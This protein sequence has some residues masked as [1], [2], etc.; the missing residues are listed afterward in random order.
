MRELPGSMT[1]SS[2]RGEALALLRAAERIFIAYSSADL[3]AA[4][5]LRRRIVRIRHDRPVESVFMASDSL[6]VG[7]SIEPAHIR[8]ALARADLFVVA[9][10]RT[11][12]GSAWVVEEVR[13]ALLQRADGRTRILPVILTAKV[14]LPP[15]I[16]FAI[17]AIHRATLFP[18]IRRVQA[19]IA[20][21]VLALLAAAIGAA[22]IALDRARQRDLAALQGRLQINAFQPGEATDLVRRNWLETQRAE[23]RRLNARVETAAIDKELGRYGT[24]AMRR[25]WLSAD[26][27][28]RFLAVDPGAPV[29]WVGY[30]DRI[31][32]RNAADGALERAFS[33]RSITAI[34]YEPPPVADATPAVKAVAT[35]RSPARLVALRADP[36]VTG[37]LAEVEYPDGFAD[38]QE[39]ESLAR[40]GYDATGGEREVFC[41]TRDSAAMQTVGL[42]L[43]LT[44]ENDATGDLGAYDAPVS[45]AD[46]VEAALSQ[47]TARQRSLVFKDWRRGDTVERIA[48]DPVTGSALF[49][50]VRDMT[51]RDDHT[52][53]FSFKGWRDHWAV[54]LSRSGQIDEAAPITKVFPAGRR[55][56]WPDGDLDGRNPFVATAPRFIPAALGAAGAL[57]GASLHWVSAA[58]SPGD[59]EA[60]WFAAGGGSLRARLR[61]GSVAT[62][63]PPGTDVRRVIRPRQVRGIDVTQDGREVLVLGSDGRIDAWSISAFGEDGWIAAREPI[64]DSPQR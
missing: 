2:P 42:S 21:T 3:A 37:V 44:A 32:A 28:R 40:S 51:S 52:A 23:A 43:R 5:D 17:H 29:V 9:C 60:I 6:P 50:V 10:G 18:A 8:D 48:V 31:E 36:R 1:A 25:V 22:V 53:P 16:D 46:A 47:P 62:A 56:A 33:L 19:V 27:A 20:V 11:T 15:G 54:R 59:V 64:S 26:F 13:Q 30:D 61:D 55:M 12:A 57:L 58:N 35:A 63:R 34:S 7:Q 38:P 4:R 49:H 14:L 39:K 24:D 41:L 45:G